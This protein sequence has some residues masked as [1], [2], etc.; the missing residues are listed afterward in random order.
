MFARQTLVLTAVFLVPSYIYSQWHLVHS[1]QD[2]IN[3][4]INIYI[5]TSKNV[6]LSKIFWSLSYE[7]INEFSLY[8]SLPVSF[9]KQH[10]HDLHLC[11]FPEVINFIGIWSAVFTTAIQVSIIPLLSRKKK[12]INIVIFPSSSSTIGV[13]IPSPSLPENRSQ[14]KK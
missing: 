10:I 7:L 6:S 4:L 11:G 8:M 14:T 1:I 12:P 5:L 13:Y 2:I 3:I 9:I